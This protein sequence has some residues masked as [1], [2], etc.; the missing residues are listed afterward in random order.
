MTANNLPKFS[1]QPSVQELAHA[2]LLG[3]SPRFI[4]SLEAI[5]RFAPTDA[6]VLLEGE[7]GTGKELAARAVH[8][9]SARKNGPFI[10]LNC[11]AVPDTLLENELFGHEK[12]AFT[13]A[14]TRHAGLVAQANG[15]T[16]FLD[17]VDSLT[18]KGQVILLR[19]LQDFSY[20]PLGSDRLETSD[21]R[22]VA[23]SNTSLEEQVVA[24][25][26]RQ[27]L[28]FRIDVARVTLPPLRQRLEDIPL[29]CTH[30]LRKFTAEYDTLPRRLDAPSLEWL[31]GR[32]WPGNVRELENVL[33][34]E[35][36]LTDGAIIH[37]DPLRYP[38]EGAVG[39]LPHSVELYDLPY[40]EA[41][42]RVI[43]SFDRRYL[44][45]LLAESG[46]NV[47]EAARR[48]GKDRCNLRRMLKKN[49]IDRIDFAEGGA[50][51]PS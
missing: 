49:H 29:L 47:T 50:S 23:A 4:Q 42:T 35:F 6:P 7:T 5:R 51:A 25:R 34:R 31:L 33:H 46:G 17:E 24:K 48:A 18:P 21:V 11:G 1:P 45:R 13:G 2:G 28:L 36:L 43:E 41:R 14:Q 8:Y 38:D 12:G 9:T 37:I 40:G 27:D 30:F 19:F 16:L 3:R 44:T 22:V 39:N 32:V 10:P 26:F 15:G 20:R